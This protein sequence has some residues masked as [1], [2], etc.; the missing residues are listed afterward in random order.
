MRRATAVL[1]LAVIGWLAVACS[2][3]A[4][5]RTAEGS[6]TPR[7]PS[8][9]S[10]SPDTSSPLGMSDE[11]P[12]WSAEFDTDLDPA[13]W[14]VSD[15]GD[16]YG[17]NEL[18]VYTPRADNVSV[19]DGVLRLTARAER[20]TDPRGFKG[21]YTSGRIETTTRFQYGRVEARIKVPQGPGLWSAFWLFGDSLSGEEWPAVG[22]IDIMELI[23]NTLDLHHAA[24]G[25]TEAGERWIRNTSLTPGEPFSD[26]WHVYAV[27]WDAD[28]MTFWVDD[29]QS[30]RV[31]KDD[32]ADNEEWPFDRPYS[33]TLNLAV[34]G[35]WPGPP[36]DE[37]VFPA[38]MLVDY[39]RVYD[40]QVSEAR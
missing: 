15:R 24:I 32:L 10:P 25:A 16:G 21:D 22:E 8:P 36:N 14:A 17:N 26:D 20:F 38:E 40:A 34:G 11:A 5:Q 39:V 3:P 6:S 23:G 13:E 29:V 30:F 28:E 27:E 19:D 4:T 35:D 1:A 2:T 12:V 37:T 33:I 31:S 9:A 18:Q 7:P